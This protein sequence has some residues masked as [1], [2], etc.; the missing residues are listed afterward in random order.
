ML[1]QAEVAGS[2][3]AEASAQKEEHPYR[4]DHVY[5]ASAL[6]VSLDELS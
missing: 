5:P 4:N 2:Y 1:E 6:H 3:H